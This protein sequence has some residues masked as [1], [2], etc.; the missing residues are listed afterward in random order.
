MDVSPPKSEDQ[1]RTWLPTEQFLE[2]E[3]S[4]TPLSREEF[5]ELC[6]SEKTAAGIEAALKAR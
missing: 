2:V 5:R 3:S 1:A 6:D 4:E